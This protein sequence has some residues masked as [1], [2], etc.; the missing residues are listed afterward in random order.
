[1]LYK[2]YFFTAKLSKLTSIC[3]ASYKFISVKILP[4]HKNYENKKCCKKKNENQ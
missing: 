2:N 3:P 4:I 1:M